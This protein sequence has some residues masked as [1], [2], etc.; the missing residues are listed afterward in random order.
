MQGSHK[1]ESVRLMRHA[2]FDAS[3]QHQHRNLLG[4]CDRDP[5]QRVRHSWPADDIHARDLC[6]LRGL[7]DASGCKRCTLLVGDQY[8]AR[9]GAFEPSIHGEI[10]DSWDAKG[11]V[12]SLISEDFRGHL[13]GAKVRGGKRVKVS[14]AALDSARRS[15]V[16]GCSAHV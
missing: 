6:A 13:R 5:G 8:G 2:S 12:H 7:K 16:T 11:K 10:L 1:L 4:V 14:G 15:A 3:R 9:S